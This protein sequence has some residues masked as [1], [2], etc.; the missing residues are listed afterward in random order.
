MT[1]TTWGTHC[2]MRNVSRITGLDC[3][4]ILVSRHENE[5]A[6]PDVNTEHPVLVLRP[7]ETRSLIYWIIFSGTVRS[8]NEISNIEF[9]NPSFEVCWV[10][11]PQNL[12]FWAGP[13]CET[14]R[15]L[16]SRSVSQISS[17]KYRGFSI[18]CRVTRRS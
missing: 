3:T 4:V 16:K 13:F 11:R 15:L 1:D 18:P 6:V 7:D 5:T 2:D 8:K 17:F 12:D 9:Q 14:D 10:I